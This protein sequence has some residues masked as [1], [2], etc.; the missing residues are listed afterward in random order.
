MIGELQMQ[1]T[2]L[3]SPRLILRLC[4]LQDLPFIHLLHSLPETDEFNTQ[5]I[6]TNPEETQSIVEQWIREHEKNPIMKY[7][8]SIVLK[9]SNEL[10][11]LVSLRLGPAKYKNGEVSYKIHPNHWKKGYATEALNS[12]I[13][14]AFHT[15]KLHRIE[16]GCAIDNI[17]SIKVLEKVGMQRDGRMRQLLPL[18]N[19]WSDNYEYSLLDTDVR[20][21]T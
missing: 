18:K 14:F 13:D 11:G 2:P 6:P 17:A 19:G 15:L 8:F 1:N 10:I 5:G 16:A 21:A 3:T 20:T 7:S 4:T 12:V 9:Q